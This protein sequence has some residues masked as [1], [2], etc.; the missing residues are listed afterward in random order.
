VQLE[1]EQ[2]DKTQFL[3]IPQN[4]IHWFFVQFCPKHNDELQSVE[5]LEIEQLLTVIYF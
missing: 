3:A 2:L 1:T 5:Q 4:S